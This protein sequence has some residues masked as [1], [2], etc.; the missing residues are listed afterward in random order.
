MQ[1]LIPFIVVGLL[2]MA[3][4]AE[5]KQAATYEDVVNESCGALARVLAEVCIV[6]FSFGSSTA[7]LVVVGDQ[8]Q[9]SKCLLL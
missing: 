8:I 7:Y 6:T 9:D 3:H 2:I 5:L 1:C 4:T